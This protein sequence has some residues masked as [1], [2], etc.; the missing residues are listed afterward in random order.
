MLN[1][2][3]QSMNFKNAFA[4]IMTADIKTSTKWYTNLFDRKS[5]YNP[6]NILHEWDFSDGGVL[7][8]VEDKERAGKSSITLLVAD[9]EKIKK[10]LDEKN[11]SREEISKGEIAKTITIFDPEK[12]RITFAENNQGR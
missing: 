5:D 11:L 2:N 10:T 7:Q 1:S 12:N 3:E 8:L 4:G 6:M 9:I